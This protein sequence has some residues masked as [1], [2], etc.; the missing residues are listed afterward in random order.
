M[1]NRAVALI[2]YWVMLPLFA[3]A[4]GAIIEHLTIFHTLRKKFFALAFTVAALLEVFG[5]L[6]AIKVDSTPQ[7]SEFVTFVIS[8][9]SKQASKHTLLWSTEALP[10]VGCSARCMC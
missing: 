2:P 3:L 4:C 8:R 5:I 7:A 9:T 10:G 1:A 6:L